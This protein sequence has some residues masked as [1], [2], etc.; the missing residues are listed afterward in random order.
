MDR[1]IKPN[2]NGKYNL[3][4]IDWQNEYEA[5]ID[6]NYDGENPPEVSPIA[7]MDAES[8]HQL[9]LEDS[10]QFRLE[11]DSLEK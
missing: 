9:M 6:S 1:P 3:N 10:V 11:Q 5:V 8:F 7:G 4:F 2:P